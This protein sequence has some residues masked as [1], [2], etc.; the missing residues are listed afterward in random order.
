MNTDAE[1]GMAF[2]RQVPASALANLC[3]PCPSVFIRG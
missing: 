1:A 3:Y 2:T